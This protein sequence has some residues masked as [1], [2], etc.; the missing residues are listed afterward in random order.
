MNPKPDE[1]PHWFPNTNVFVSKSG[2]LVIKVALSGL[3]AGD[4]EITV[5][6]KKLRIKG[7][8]H[9][10]EMSHSR[11]LLVNEIPAGPFES[12]L[13]VPEGFDLSASSSAYLNGMLRIVV[14]PKPS[15]S[16]TP[17]SPQRN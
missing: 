7:A 14:P 5:E 9:D 13:E 12:V 8:R 10:P 11:Q 4:V 3:V 15:P 2:H 6:N 16:G 1:T 17:P